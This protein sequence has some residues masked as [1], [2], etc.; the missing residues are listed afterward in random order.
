MRVRQAEADDAAAVAAFTRDTWPDRDGTDYLPDVFVEWV[1]ADDETQRTSVATVDGDPIGVVQ[2]VLLSEHEAWQQGMRVHPDYRGEGVG[3]ALSHAGF[4]W[5]RD[6]GATVARDM[7]FSWNERG[8]G[9]SRAAGFGPGPEF[10]WAH[11]EPTADARVTGTVTD[12]PRAAWSHWRESRAAAS[13]DGLGLSIDESWALAEV[14]LAGLERARDEESLLVV[15][16]GGTAAVAYR[17]RVAERE[18]DDGAETW[19]DYGAAAWDDLE[20]AGDLFAAIARDAAGAGADRVR[21]LVPETTRA[22]SDAAAARVAVSDDPD[23]V[24]AADL[25]GPY[26]ERSHR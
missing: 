22:V 15:D 7:V 2:T 5:A 24:F 16:G 11:P 23:F 25:T 19:A 3:I 14:S 1:A 6:R 20:A 13:L 10:R 26:R 21:V 4:D 12:E 9:L 17:S 8:L 18:T